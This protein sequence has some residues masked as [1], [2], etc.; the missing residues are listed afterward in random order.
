MTDLANNIERARR[1]V[2]KRWLLEPYLYS[3]PAKMTFEDING[4]LD[5]LQG[6]INECR[7]LYPRTSG[8]SSGDQ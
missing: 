3:P 5:E 7:A 4:A 2:I 6:R 8:T 1:S